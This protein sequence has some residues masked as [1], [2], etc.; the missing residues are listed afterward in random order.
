MGKLL[1]L[2]FEKITHALHTIKNLTGGIQGGKHI[3]DVTNASRT[4]F[5]NLKSR[6][7]DQRLLE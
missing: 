6:Q 3:T 2:T 4:M 7:W 5:M 1:S